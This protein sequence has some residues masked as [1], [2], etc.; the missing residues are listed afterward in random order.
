MRLPTI[1]SV[2]VS[3]GLAALIVYTMRLP[4][5][6]KIPAPAS[7]P[8]V[9]VVPVPPTPQPTLVVARP[10]DIDFQMPVRP[11]SRSRIVDN[12]FATEPAFAAPV[13]WK[14]NSVITAALKHEWE[15]VRK[16]ID[17]GAPA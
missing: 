3:L 15:T 12:C 5:H 17:A 4:G 11:V 7:A 14:E 10:I 2:F 8:T 1:R 9:A 13:I 16:L 6:G